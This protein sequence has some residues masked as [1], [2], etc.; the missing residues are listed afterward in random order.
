[1]GEDLFDRIVRAG[2]KIYSILITNETLDGDAWL[3]E[4]E[5]FCPAGR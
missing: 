2:K 4:V 3:R 1:V 5:I